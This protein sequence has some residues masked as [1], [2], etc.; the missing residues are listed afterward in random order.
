MTLLASTGTP[1]FTVGIPDS[2]Q[3]KKGSL[4]KVCQEFN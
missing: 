2:S 1:V 4:Y 3:I